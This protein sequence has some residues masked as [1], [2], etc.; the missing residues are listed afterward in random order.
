M[1]PLQW[2][3]TRDRGLSALRRAA[4]TAIIMPLMFALGDK[5]FGDP[6][7][8]TFAAFGSFAML[9]LVDFGGRIRDRVQAQ[10]ALAVTGGVF[11]CVGTVASRNPWSAAISMAV[12]GFIVLF[13]GVVSSVLAAASTSL[14]LAF[15]LPV[16]LAAPVST[17]GA[18]LAGWGLA[19]AVA[20]VAIA[21]LWPAPVRDVLRG[22]AGAAVRAIAGRLRAEVAYVLGGREETP[23]HKDAI[24]A[25]K[26]SVA[27]L[28]QVFLATP[29]RPTGLSTSARAVVRLVDELKWLDVILN[30]ATLGRTGG[31]VNRAACAVKSCAADVLEAGGDL[32]DH[33]GNP[34]DRLHTALDGLAAA[35]GRLE[36]GATEMLPVVRSSATADAPDTEFLSALDPSFR[37]QELTFAVRAV[38]GN[39]DL[40]AAAERRSWIA[41]LLGRQPTGLLGPVAAAGQ[42]AFAHFDR[43][44][45]WLHNSLRGSIGL[46][47]AVL[48]ADLSAVQHSFWVVLATLSVLRSNALNTGQNALRGLAGT[49]VGFVVGAALL[50]LVGTDSTAL[51]VLLPFSILL[52]GLAPAVISFVAGQA[53][54]T[55]V[56]VILFNI[57]AP[58]GWHVGLV[59][60]EDIAIGCGVSLVVG[61]LFWPRGAGAALGR[62]LAEAYTDGAQYLADAV[63]FGVLRCDRTG[64]RPA[65]PDDSSSRAAAASRRLDDTFR[66]YLA[67]RGSKPVPLAEVTTL[68]TGTAAL[69]LAGDAVLDLWQRDDGVPDGDRAAARHELLRTCDLVTRW[70]LDLA[71]GFVD[72]RSIPEPQPHDTE[73]DGRLVGAVRNDLHSPDGNTSITAVRMIWTADHLDAA[74]R[75]QLMLAGPAREAQRRR[76]EDPTARLLAGHLHL[77]R[78]PSA[79]SRAVSG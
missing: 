26:A 56:I 11:V 36:Q 34:V 22:P 32:L 9:L 4:R 33:L 40:A 58:A 27:A 55:L 70:Y 19:S 60:V 79:L 17:L 18:R 8:A 15:I 77:R 53:A 39:I 46:G 21:V 62:A 69:R 31:D 64:P 44:S 78:R 71:G 66:T 7:L 50:A 57:I 51:W 13:A 52:A 6:N 48:V 42:R 30:Q 1:H 29:N 16:S 24:A 5:V 14:L 63:L 37:A 20:T 73:A 72:G 10:L 43:H 76:S 45:V 41:R 74:R 2:L 35:L 49:V 12:V 23:E 25:G 75:L 67:E 38:A 47:L 68:V 65:P 59:R 28:Q 3:A 54:F 61:A